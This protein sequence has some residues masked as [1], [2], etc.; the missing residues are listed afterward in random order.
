MA[1]LSQEEIDQLLEAI[2]DSPSPGPGLN[3]LAEP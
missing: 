3:I 1:E 2:N